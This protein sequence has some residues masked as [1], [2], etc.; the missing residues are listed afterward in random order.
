MTADHSPAAPGAP[1][2]LVAVVVTHNRL[3]K[4]RDTLAR[5]LE[6][7]AEVLQAVV[8][9]DNV[10]TDGTGAWLA[11]QDDPRL[12]VLESAENLGGAG[13]FE[14]G[15][16]E[17]VTR[18]D[19]DWMVVMDDDARPDPGALA[20]FAALDKRDCEAVAAAVYFPG[21]AI[22]EM[23]RPSRNPFW[24]RREFLRTVVGG[25][26]GFH[27][28][29][30]DYRGQ[31]RPVDVSSFVGLFVSRRAVELVGYPD[32]RLFVYG[33]DGLYTLG[34]SKAGGRI[35]FSPEVRFEH[36]CSTFQGRPGQFRPLWKVYY[37]HR[38]LLFLYRMAAGWMFWPVMLLILPK[39]L[40]K[41]RHHPGERGVFLRLLGWAVRDGLS[42][43]V[44]RRHAEVLAAAG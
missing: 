18:F 23:N 30:A 20:A 29:P 33:E 15:M 16:R 24:H 40:L 21:G 39:W 43:R 2:S 3:E 38:N 14:W 27:I 6:A 32:G 42:G 1:F 35:H 25:R 8:V 10:S 41:L 12:V 36:D 19:P 13:G 37:Y 28:A 7:D 26:G 5:L 4:L 44:D 9:V 22:C 17:A 31:G 11:G 34:L